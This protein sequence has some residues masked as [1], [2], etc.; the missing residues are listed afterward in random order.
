MTLIRIPQKLEI[1]FWNLMI[2]LMEGS[3]RL[4]YLIHSSCGW[5]EKAQSRTFWMP[6]VIWAS[7]GL[8]LGLVLGFVAGM[9]K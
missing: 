5:A 1:A 9:L 4:A 3:P 6:F 8:S 7:T 2:P